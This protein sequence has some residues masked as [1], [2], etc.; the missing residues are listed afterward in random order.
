MPFLPGGKYQGL[1]CSAGKTLQKTPGRRQDG[2]FPGK[3]G[4]C[5][6]RKREAHP[7][8]DVPLQGKILSSILKRNQKAR[9]FTRTVVTTTKA[10]IMKTSAVVSAVP[11]F[12]G[13]DGLSSGVSAGGV[14]GVSEGSSPPGSEVG[15]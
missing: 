7:V 4:F 2:S 14:S 1:P 3:H 11:V 15:T 13:L 10:A 9:F 12:P 6:K 8:Q 5:P